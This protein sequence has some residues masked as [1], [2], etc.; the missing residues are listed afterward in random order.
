MPSWGGIRY[1]PMGLYSTNITL[2]GRIAFVLARFVAIV[3]G[4]E[5]LHARFADSSRRF[6]AAARE[7]LDAYDGEFRVINGGTEGFYHDPVNDRAEALNHMAWA[8]CALLT[9]KKL[10]GETK[11]GTM[12]R[13][14]AGFFRS[15]MWRDAHGALVWRYDPTPNDRRGGHREFVWKARTTVQFPL[16][17][18]ENGVLFSLGDVEAIA[19]M[20]VSNV[21]RGGAISAVIDSYKDLEPYRSFR[22]GYLSLTPFIVLARFR[23]EI[24]GIIE[25]VVGSRPDIGGWFK[26]LHG[27]VAYA[28]RMEPR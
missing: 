9:L 3:E 2:A 22:G 26:S 17:A 21:Y 11:Y 28:Y 5:H 1:H 23:P 19:D 16:C 14:L 24:R 6:L 4:N 15:S 12:A 13:Q 20:F 27:A 7:A 18:Y 10:T 25:A 8:G